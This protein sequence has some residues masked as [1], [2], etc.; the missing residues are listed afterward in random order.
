MNIIE[1]QK[2]AA[3]RGDNMSDMIIQ[4]YVENEAFFGAMEFIEFG[5][6]MSYGWNEEKTLPNGENRGF[7]ENYVGA[8]GETK[9]MQE[10]LKIY[11]GKI[12]VDRLAVAQLGNEIVMKKQESQMKAIRLKIM[13]DFFNG[14]SATDIKQMDGLKSFLPTATAGRIERGYIADNGGAAL[15]RK[16]LDEIIGNTDTDGNTVIFADKMVPFYINQYGESLVTFDKNEFGVP[17]ARYGDVPIITVD[18]NSTNA[19]ILGFTEASNTSSL[20]L[21][22]L[23]VDKVAML[24]GAGGML[25]SNPEASGSNDIYQNDWLLAVALQGQYNAARLHNFTAATMVA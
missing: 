23:D 15:S 6:S 9:P 7:N 21:A 12:S 22:N 18:R 24:S 14:S 1:L 17:V 10:G 3:A 25:T 13:N 16:K 2:L 19:K 20:F 4:N 8:N 5:G 11:G